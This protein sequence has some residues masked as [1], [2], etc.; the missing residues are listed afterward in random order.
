MVRQA[1]VMISHENTLVWLLTCIVLYCISMKMHSIWWSKKYDSTW[2]H[3]KTVCYKIYYTVTQC[4]VMVCGC[5]QIYFNCTYSINGIP[6]IVLPWSTSSITCRSHSVL[7]KFWIDGLYP[8][9]SQRWQSCHRD[10]LFNS[11]F[12]LSNTISQI[13]FGNHLGQCFVNILCTTWNHKHSHLRKMHFTIPSAT[14]LP[15]CLHTIIVL[16]WNIT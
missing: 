13:H 11:V 2:K 15:Y 12:R 16:K 9:W 10:S 5:S 4:S 3:N 1:W 8:P 14:C 7:D 6:V